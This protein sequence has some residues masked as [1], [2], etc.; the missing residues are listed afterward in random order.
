MSR[1][2]L[3]GLKEKCR[4]T[5]ALAKALKLVRAVMAPAIRFVQIVAAVSSFRA[6][7]VKNETVCVVMPQ[8]VNNA[9]VVTANAK[10]SVRF[11]KGR[12]Q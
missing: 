11:V 10:F 9:T 12:E 8:A 6:P 3:V 5:A 1:A 4:A 2:T 7:M